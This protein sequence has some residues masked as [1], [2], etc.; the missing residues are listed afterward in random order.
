MAPPSF[1]DLGKQARD[2]LSKS[3]VTGQWKVEA[4]TKAQSNFKVKATMVNNT[5]NNVNLSS[6]EDEFS[7]PDYGLKF[8]EKWNTDNTLATEVVIEDQ[9]LAG[10]KTSFDTSFNPSSGKK[11]GVVKNSYK[12]ERVSLDLDLDFTYSGV[13]IKGSSVA[14]YEGWLAGAQVNFDTAAGKVATHNVSLGYLGKDY[15]VTAFCKDARDFEGSYYHN[16]N[17]E[18]EVAATGTYSADGN[19]PG[20]NLAAKYNLSDET[21]LKAKVNHAGEVTFSLQQKV[22]KGLSLTLSSW[23]NARNFH[24]GGHKVGFALELDQ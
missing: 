24:A 16:V 10:L 9:L 1:S 15:A 13:Q 4:K 11:K 18:W 12:H 3:F 21:N 7:W 23:I 8:V 17:P 19:Q 20:V 22:A 2:L 6:I 5:D 14:G